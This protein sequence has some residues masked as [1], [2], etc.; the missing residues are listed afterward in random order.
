MRLADLRPGMEHLD[1]RVRVT[2]LKEIRKIKTY[3]GLEHS[4]VEGEV[5][6]DSGNVSFTVWNEKISELEGIKVRDLI[7]IKNCFITSFKGVIQI[8]VGRDSSI[9]KVG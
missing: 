1:F 7:E 3:S 4:L 6:D 8:N 2:K 9:I 5:A